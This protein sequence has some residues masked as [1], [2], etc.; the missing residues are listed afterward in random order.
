MAMLRWTDSGLAKSRNNNIL[1]QL[2]SQHEA[3]VRENRE[4]LRIIFETVA[5]LGKQNI[6]FRG[7]SEDRTRLTE[8]SD[9]NRQIS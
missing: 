2:N 6:A 9:V 7:S 5:Y 1:T 4:Y 8:L 3:E